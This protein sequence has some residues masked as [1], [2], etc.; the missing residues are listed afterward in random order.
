M[1]E[2]NEPPK[3]AAAVS[4]SSK[5]EENCDVV[6]YSTDILEKFVTSKVI[7]YGIFGVQG[8]QILTN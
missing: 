4:T 6:T 5:S 7:E 2:K 1:D 8:S 3:K